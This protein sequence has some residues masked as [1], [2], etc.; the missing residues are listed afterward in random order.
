[1]TEVIINY[2]NFRDCWT[3][4]YVGVDVHMYMYRIY[5]DFWFYYIISD[6]LL[7][8]YRNLGC[9]SWISF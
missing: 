6:K 9:Y 5:V 8:W 7:K 1:M 4:T 2:L 3:H